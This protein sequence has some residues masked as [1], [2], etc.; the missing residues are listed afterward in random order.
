M[1]AEGLLRALMQKNPP[2]YAG[3][4]VL[5]LDR[6]AR[7]GRMLGRAEEADRLLQEA[8]ACA[9]QYASVSGICARYLAGRKA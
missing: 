2:F 4:M 1:E 8:A 7:A 3:S 9:E 5:T 6:Q